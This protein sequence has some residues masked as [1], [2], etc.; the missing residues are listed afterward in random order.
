L[1]YAKRSWLKIEEIKTI[2]EEQEYEVTFKFDRRAVG[3]NR[4]KTWRHDYLVGKLLINVN[5]IQKK[6][7]FMYIRIGKFMKI[8]KGR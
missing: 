6:Y 5:N 7:L 8:L 3:Y 4:V 1:L 2:K